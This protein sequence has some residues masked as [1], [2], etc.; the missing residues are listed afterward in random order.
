M[1][2]DIIHS[3]LDISRCCCIFGYHRAI[4]GLAVL[5]FVGCAP[6]ID[7]YNR[8][9]LVQDDSGQLVEADIVQISDAV[10]GISTSDPA[11]SCN[12]IADD[13]LT[14]VENSCRGCHADDGDRPLSKEALLRSSACEGP[15]YNADNPSNSMLLEMFSGRANC[16]FSGVM[17]S[18]AQNVAKQP[19]EIDCLRQWL[20]GLE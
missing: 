8:F 15:L 11:D 12:D 4:Y 17:S 1:K 10:D 9:G 6:E 16:K 3:L 2:T 20:I 13:P 18:I 14:Y 19:A 7:N 5:F